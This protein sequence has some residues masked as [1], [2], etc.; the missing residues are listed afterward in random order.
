MN[1]YYPQRPQPPRR[2][3]TLLIVVAVVSAVV[4]I[5][6]VTVVAAWFEHDQALQAAG[7]DRAAVTA[8]EHVRSGGATGDRDAIDAINAAAGSDSPALREAA[9]RYLDEPDR[10]ALDQREAMLRIARWCLENGVNG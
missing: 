4:L 10:N 6:V 9:A 5:L 2:N 1:P 8:C 3:H 7:G